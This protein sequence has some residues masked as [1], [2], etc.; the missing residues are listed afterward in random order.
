MKE[1]VVDEEPTTI[2]KLGFTEKEDQISKEADEMM[3]DTD[4][5]VAVKS[6]EGKDGAESEQEEEEETKN[7]QSKNS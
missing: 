6:K 7:S 3:E 2:I 5:E 1:P 4:V